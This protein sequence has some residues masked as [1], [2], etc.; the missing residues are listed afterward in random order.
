MLQF[1]LK[2]VKG[3]T[4]GKDSGQETSKETSKERSKD[5][6]DYKTFWNL[7]K[8]R[9]HKLNQVKD[10]YGQIP[11]KTQYAILKATDP[12]LQVM[13]HARKQKAEGVSRAWV[14]LYEIL[15]QTHCLES[16]VARIPSSLGTGKKKVLSIFCNAELPGSFLTCI[17]HYVTTKFPLNRIE[18]KWYA[19][20]L[21]SQGAKTALG[22]S[23]GLVSLY[24]QQW[25]QDEKMNGDVTKIE[26]ILAIQKKLTQHQHKVWFYTSDIGFEVSNPSQQEAQ[27]SLVHYGQTLCG[28]STL[29]KRGSM[30]LKQYTF[31]S[32]ASVYL[33]ALFCR[34]FDQVH[35]IKP[36]AS[37]PSNSEIYLLLEDYQGPLQTMET[38]FFS[39]L[40]ETCH[41]RGTTP[42]DLQAECYPWKLEPEF[43]DHLLTVAQYLSQNQMDALQ[44]LLDYPKLDKT[45]LDSARD[46]LAQEFL[47]KYPIHSLKHSL[48]KPFKRKHWK[49]RKE[50]KDELAET[51]GKKRKVSS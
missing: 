37:R 50:G 14:K 45:I 43:C 2:D 19:S 33:L 20:S 18:L 1:N 44:F 15:C 4:Y 42:F 21:H 46:Q 39:Q 40:L 28:L 35:M 51:F 22:D 31:A 11:G 23:Y 49:K 29:E 27:T 34:K 5:A 9:E 24:P 17:H 25:F 41:M 48:I 26:N 12:Y 10:Q 13:T 47:T 32:P 30:I 38:R 3:G 8:D 7:L 36:V 6:Y 16:V